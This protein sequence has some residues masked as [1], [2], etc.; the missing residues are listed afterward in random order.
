MSLIVVPLRV[1][2]ENPSSKST[3]EFRRTFAG[4]GF[5]LWRYP[6]RARVPARCSGVIRSAFSFMSTHVARVAPPCVRFRRSGA[7]WL[8][9]LS[10]RLKL[11]Q[12]QHNKALHPTAYSS[13]RCV[14]SSLRSAESNDFEMSIQINA[15]E[16]KARV[17]LKPVP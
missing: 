7:A 10:R 2:D 16:R 12:Q 6:L 11:I 8:R 9:L 3:P 13:V 15:E 4:K 14:R 1:L 5:R 17:K